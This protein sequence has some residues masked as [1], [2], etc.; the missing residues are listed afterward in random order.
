M[1]NTKIYLILI[2]LTQC[3]DHAS[4]EKSTT[5]AAD[6]MFVNEQLKLYYM[7]YIYGELIIHHYEGNNNHVFVQITNINF[8]Q[9]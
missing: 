8:S 4:D 7:H 9:F 5:N 6:I 3:H 1:F 2:L